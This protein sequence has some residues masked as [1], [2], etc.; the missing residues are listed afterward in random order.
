MITENN[1]LGFIGLLKSFTKPF[2]VASAME[3]FERWAWYGLFA[4]L[5]LYLTGSIDEG[6]L[7]F[8]HVERGEIMSYVTFIL[9]LLPIITGAISDK[10]GYKLSLIIAYLL[11]GI[12]YYY[13]GNVTSY[14][15]VFIMFLIVAIGAAMFK[16]VASA[17]VTKSTDNRNSSFGFGVFYMMVNIGGFF[18]PLFSAKLRDEY[19]WKIVFIMATVAIAINLIIVILFFKEPNREKNEDSLGKTIIKSLKNIFEALSDM[20][21]TLLLLIMVGFWLMFNQLFYTLPV[22][23]EEWVNTKP[24]Y[25]T[26]SNYTPWIAEF[27]KNKHGGINPEMVVN[28]DAFFIVI[29]QMIVSTIILKWK[30]INAMMT[31]IFIAVIG[32]ALSFYTS[33]VFFTIFGILIFAIGEMTSNPKFSDYIAKISPKGKEALYMGTYFLPIAFANLLTKWITGDL[34]EKM[35]DKVLLIR[36]ELSTKNI[37]LPQLDENYTKNNFYTEA[38]EKLQMTQEQMTTHVWNNYHPGNIWF[39]IAGIGMLT[40]IGLVI[41]DQVIKRKEKNS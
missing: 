23:I 35:S 34:Y 21:L 8:T 41:Y 12:G 5:A 6:A 40:I 16:P 38:A 25:D 2:W 14:P 29:L 31:G 33:N 19:G 11:L 32:I 10:I 18:G 4:V 22:F 1:D 17:I 30:P 26:L 3:L 36:K 24:L 37:E 28:L 7:G 20:K 27:F 13:M 39:V 9:Y 15:A